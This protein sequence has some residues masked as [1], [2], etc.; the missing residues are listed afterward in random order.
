MH[1]DWLP[2]GMFACANVDMGEDPA[3]TPAQKCTTFSGFFKNGLRSSEKK[4]RY[5]DCLLWNLW[6]T[7]LIIIGGPKYQVA[8]ALPPPPQSGF[9]CYWFTTNQHS[10]YYWSL[11][12]YQ[13]YSYQILMELC[14]K[15][16]CIKHTSFRSSQRCS[17]GLTFI[18]YVTSQWLAPCTSSCCCPFPRC[19]WWTSCCNNSGLNW[20][21]IIQL[22]LSRYELGR[23]LVVVISCW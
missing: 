11:A 19:S 6:V 23:G 2:D 20:W 4:N 12:D 3:N 18:R 15:R 22:C 9:L 1:F 8:G 10:R 13:V 7:P 5:F 16:I 21:K 14:I 17:W